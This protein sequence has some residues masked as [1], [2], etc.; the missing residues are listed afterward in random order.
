MMPETLAVA[1]AILGVIGAGGVLD[2]RLPSAQ[3]RKIL[4][5][6]LRARARLGPVRRQVWFVRF[7]QSLSR[8]SSRPV[9]RW[10]LLLASGL[11]FL[12]LQ[13]FQPSGDHALISSP[14][15]VGLDARVWFAI[16]GGA[17][18][19]WIDRL[20][21]QTLSGIRARASTLGIGELMIVG[22]TWAALALLAAAALLFLFASV[23]SFV[24]LAPTAFAQLA[25]ARNLL[26]RDAFS[27]AVLPIVNWLVAVAVSTRLL[28]FTCGAVLAAASLV[29]SLVAAC[30][31]APRLALRALSVRAGQIKYIKTEYKPFTTLGG[32]TAIGIAVLKLAQA[33]AGALG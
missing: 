29:A 4:A 3:K 10:I 28:P 24:R 15:G 25:L 23:A 5:G 8:R 18:H 6:V 31:Y 21:L 9:P 19:I 11:I 32:L 12:L 20:L 14:G 26:E 13:G 16:V 22:L 7:S 17:L 33:A 2:A 1:L 30:R 27:F